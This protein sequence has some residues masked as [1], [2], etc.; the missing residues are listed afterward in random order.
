M[1]LIYLMW[2]PK[3][4]FYANGLANSKLW[5]TCVHQ[6]RSIVYAS[7]VKTSCTIVSRTSHWW[8]YNNHQLLWFYQTLWQKGGGRSSG[9]GGGSRGTRL[10]ALFLSPFLFINF[11][12]CNIIYVLENAKM[13]PSYRQAP[14]LTKDHFL[15]VVKVKDLFVSFKHKN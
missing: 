5:A 10:P 8:L 2:P 14:S 15:G 4:C 9:F 6:I 12:L 11:I 1:S 13:P 3:I 7:W